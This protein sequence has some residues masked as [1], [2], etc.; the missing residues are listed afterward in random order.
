MNYVVIANSMDDIEIL[1]PFAVDTS[2]DSDLK[3]LNYFKLH[4][5]SFPIAVYL[6]PGDWSIGTENLIKGYT[7]YQ[8]VS[9]DIFKHPH[10]YP[11]YF[12]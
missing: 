1:D 3:L 7:E 5:K 4:K 6:D 12:I 11:E 10:L 2:G 8:L 9:I